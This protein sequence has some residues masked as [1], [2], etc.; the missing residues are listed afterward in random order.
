MN[1]DNTERVTERV[2]VTL[3]AS[4][5]VFL[6]GLIEDAAAEHDRF[7]ARVLD[8]GAEQWDGDWPDAAER[9]ARRHSDAAR[10]LLIILETVRPEDPTRTRNGREG[11]PAPATRSSPGSVR[12]RGS[13]GL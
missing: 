2:T 3:S 12:H 13:L 11:S 9:T 8:G 4:Q 7:V 10:S 5:L 1:E 6:R